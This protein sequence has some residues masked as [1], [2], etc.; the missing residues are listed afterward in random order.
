MRG[1]FA[2]III[3][4]V[5]GV[6]LIGAELFIPGGIVGT[7]GALATLAAIVLAFT[8]EGTLFGI[9]LGAL[10]VIIIPVFFYLLSK[11]MALRAAISS[12]SI[13]LG[14]QEDYMQLVGKSGL[15]ITPLRPAGIV[16]IDNKKYDVITTGM[17]VEKGKEVKVV[18]V[19]GNK[20]FVR[21]V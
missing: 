1:G 9:I 20:I 12:K 17:M 6:A 11:T 8:T 13:P 7:V 16:V 19:E 3:L 15:A 5:I 18:K 14:I 21:E 2:G 4:F 10:A